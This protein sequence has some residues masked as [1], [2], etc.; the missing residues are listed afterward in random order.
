MTYQYFRGRK[1]H[2]RRAVTDNWSASAP[3]Q[4]R[5]QYSKQS[6]QANENRQY[7][8]DNGTLENIADNYWST[9]CLLFLIQDYLICIDYISINKSKQQ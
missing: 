1:D 7:W 2:P 3:M 4:I 6:S 9:A 8:L 5:T